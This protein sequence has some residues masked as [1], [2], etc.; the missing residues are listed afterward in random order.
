METREPANLETLMYYH[1]S[2]EKSKQ[3]HRFP[4]RFV[5]NRRLARAAIAPS[6]ITANIKT[7][8]QAQ[9]NSLY[10]EAARPS[11]ATS[12]FEFPSLAGLDVRFLR[13]RL[14]KKT[15]RHYDFYSCGDQPCDDEGQTQSASQLPGH[16]WAHVGAA[17][18]HRWVP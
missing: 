18:L 16:S 9:A 2:M 5:A 6:A 12:S 7:V 4:L 8:F 17:C 11:P 14:E 1:Y 10:L 3:N 15:T 13:E